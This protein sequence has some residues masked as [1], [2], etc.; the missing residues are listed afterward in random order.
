MGNNTISNKKRLSILFYITM[1]LLLVIMGRLAQLMFFDAEEL[2]GRAEDQWTRELAVSPKRGAILDRNG[3]ILATSATVES[4][5]L[6]PKDIEDPGEVANLL[7][8]ILQMETQEV[9]DKAADKSKVEVWLKRK[10]TN[11]QAEEIRALAARVL[12]FDQVS[13]SAVGKVEDQAFYEKLVK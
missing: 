5:L 2:S 10:I 4:V 1:L 9:F 3:E 7:A 6:Y 13:I 8:P 11:E 12:D